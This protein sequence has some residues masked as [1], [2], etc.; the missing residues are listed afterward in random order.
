M[1]AETVARSIVEDCFRQYLRKHVMQPLQYISSGSRCVRSEAFSPS[2]APQ[3]GQGTRIPLLQVLTPSFYSQ[4]AINPDPGVLIASILE[5]PEESR[6]LSVEPDSLALKVLEPRG[7]LQAPRPGLQESRLDRLRWGLARFLCRQHGPLLL[8]E[9]VRDARSQ[10]ESLQYLEAVTVLR[11]SDRAAG[12][13]PEVL[14]GVGW[15]IGAVLSWLSV[16]AVAQCF[17]AGANGSAEQHY[18]A[19]EIVNVLFASVHLGLV[20][21]NLT[22]GR[23]R[24]KLSS[25]IRI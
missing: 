11:L 20:M 3:E 13:M 12:G 2:D 9:F 1:S 24:S 21:K 16:R 14:D 19:M 6:T 7:G 22:I 15:I 4:L 23:E 25:P 8:D 18:H 10:A 17:Q 5:Q